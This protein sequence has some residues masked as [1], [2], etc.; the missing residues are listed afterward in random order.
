MNEIYYTYNNE[1]IASCIMLET[2]S[3]TQTIDIARTCL[4]LPFL[5]DDKTVNYFR[6]A[7][8][9][10]LSL[11]SLLATKPHLFTSFNKRF[12]ALLP[13]T[14]NS[15]MILSKSNRIDISANISLK[16]NILSNNIEIGNRF[17][18]IKKVLPVLLKMIEKH[19]TTKLYQLLNI[20]L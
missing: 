16:Q 4:L 10:H 11:E 12:L 5:L 17:N 7:N 1:A 19:D 6:T 13:I 8:L 14:I 2:L 15:L 20:Q 9:D 18:E 3:Q